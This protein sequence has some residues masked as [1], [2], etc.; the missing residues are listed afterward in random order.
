MAASVMPAST[1]ALAAKSSNSRRDERREHARHAHVPHPL[2]RE[3]DAIGGQVGRVEI[4]AAEA[5]D[6]E[7]EQ[8]RETESS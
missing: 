2:E 3:P 8:A 6:L 7:I 5:I 1:R 4:H